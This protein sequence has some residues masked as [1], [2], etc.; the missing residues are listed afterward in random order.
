MATVV[1]RN[2]H[3]EPRLTRV[4]GESDCES[5]CWYVCV[6]VHVYCVTMGT[7]RYGKG[8]LAPRKGK[9]VCMLCFIQINYHT[10][11]VAVYK[12]N[13]YSLRAAFL[14]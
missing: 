4:N 1:S 3:I 6:C 13:F 11:V 8:A 12:H 2:F 5:G 9:W 7:W 10:D 14:T